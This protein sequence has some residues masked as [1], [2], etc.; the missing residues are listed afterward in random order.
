LFNGLALPGAG[1]P[2][3]AALLSAMGV[4]PRGA[5]VAVLEAPGGRDHEQASQSGREGSLARS[6]RTKARK[7]S[8]VRV[9]STSLLWDM[10][11]GPEVDLQAPAGAERL[12][13]DVVVVPSRQ[14]ARPLEALHGAA[15]QRRQC[16]H[17]PHE[18]PRLEAGAASWN[19]PSAGELTACPIRPT[20]SQ[21][22]RPTTSWP[23][24]TPQEVMQL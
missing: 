7:V 13:L 14:P 18:A 11:C 22:S 24:M 15:V 12:D 4:M 17:H 8:P 3:T 10:L 1:S 19:R 21:A 6:H 2:L 23:H 16:D 9:R 5:G 20:P